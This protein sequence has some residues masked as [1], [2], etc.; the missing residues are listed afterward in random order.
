MR[1]PPGFRDA[2]EEGARNEKPSIIGEAESKE[3][4]GDNDIYRRPFEKVLVGGKEKGRAGKVRGEARNDADGEA[5]EEK[6][7]PEAAIENKGN[8]HAV[9]DAG[10]PSRLFTP[11]HWEIL[12]SDTNVLALTGMLSARETYARSRK[13]TERRGRIRGRREA[14]DGHKR[15]RVENIGSNIF[16]E[17][18]NC[19]TY[20]KSLPMIVDTGGD[21]TK[22][23]SRKGLDTSDNASTQT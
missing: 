2:E 6:A 9:D 8:E 23:C 13:E 16:D 11:L 20:D 17:V 15:G 12:R 21:D 5:L 18:E 10:R 19:N 1:K 14:T 22:S 3:K 4:G 7:P